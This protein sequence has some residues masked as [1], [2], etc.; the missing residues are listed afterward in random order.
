MNLSDQQLILV[1]WQM[2]EPGYQS[3]RSC[4]AWRLSA[5]SALSGEIWPFEWNR[6]CG[7]IWYNVFMNIYDIYSMILHVHI[8]ADL[9]QTSWTPV[10][11]CSHCSASH[12]CVARTTSWRRVPWLLWWDLCWSFSCS[13]SPVAKC[14]WW[15]SING[16][17]PKWLVYFMEN[18][19]QMDDN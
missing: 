1:V 11:R 3:S 10:F 5:L 7:T 13:V 9:H 12:C 14:I 4:E 2:P 17:S 19:V 6:F 8:L 18:P 15:F 16:G